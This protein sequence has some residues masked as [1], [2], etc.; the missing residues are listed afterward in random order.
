MI[1]Y[2]IFN[3]SNTIIPLP[4]YTDEYSNIC[5]K[6]IISRE[7]PND[8]KSIYVAKYNLIKLQIF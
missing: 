5:S 4:E 1:K 2:L 8:K 6:F 7:N 3:Q